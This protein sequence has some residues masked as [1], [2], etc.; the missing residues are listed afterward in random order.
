MGA[1]PDRWV[2]LGLDPEQHAAAEALS[3]P[4]RRTFRVAVEAQA[5][6]ALLAPDDPLDAEPRWAVTSGRLRELA[7]N[8]PLERPGVG[9]FVLAEPDPA[10]ES[11]V[12]QERLPR[13]TRFI[14]RSTR[15]AGPQLVAANVDRVWVVTSPNDDF[16]PRRLERYLATV[17]ASGARP[18]L[19]LNKAD[20]VD[21]PDVWLA[22]MAE[23]AHDAPVLATSTL[24]GA[25]LAELEAHLSSGR[26]L[27]LVGSSGVGK[28]SLVNALL[29]A[30]KQAVGAIREADDRGRHTTTHRELLR[31]PLGPAGQDRGLLVD[32]PGMRAL[33]LWTE[34]EGLLEA[35]G[36]IAGLAE[37]CRFRDCRHEREP[38]CAVRAAVAAGQL[39]AGRLAS[40]LTLVREVR[41]APPPRP[42]RPTRR[43]S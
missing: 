23:V 11:W 38:D 27:A 25:G 37:G 21:Q 20:L 28:S 30:E 31:L 18:L 22:R 26:T 4:E 5:H 10:G 3:R 34:P 24:T 17:H 8:A 33:G 9:D 35:F 19:I 36:D 1:V 43:R 39:S 15:R 40:Y 7:R 29:G 13:R 14:R 32:T 6:F 42:R 16:N 2:R 41:E 12:I